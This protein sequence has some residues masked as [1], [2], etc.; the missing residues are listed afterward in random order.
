MDIEQTDKEQKFVF[1]TEVA[2]AE[3]IADG[4]R[5]FF[6]DVFLRIPGDRLRIPGNKE[7]EVGIVVYGME[8]NIHDACDILKHI[9]KSF[10]P[11]R[12]PLPE[13]YKI[14]EDGILMKEGLIIDKLE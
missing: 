3:I 10:A 14:N 9:E 1:L 4:L 5:E 11:A 8:L 12:R 2:R 6:E 13:N 7:D